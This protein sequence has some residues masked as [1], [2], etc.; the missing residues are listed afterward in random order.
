MR[1]RFDYVKYDDV[2]AEKQRQLKQVF[3]DLEF[4]VNALLGHAG[5]S[6]AR[7]LSLTALEEAYMWVGKAIRDE[8]LARGGDA[9]DQPHRG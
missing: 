8:Q 2:A 9:T 1:G 6:R 7:A 3:E 5:C 4:R